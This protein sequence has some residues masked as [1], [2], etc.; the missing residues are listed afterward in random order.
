[1]KNYEKAFELEGI[2]FLVDNSSI[3]DIQSLF[4]RRSP[5]AS[6]FIDDPNNKSCPVPIALQQ[7]Q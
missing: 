3:Q 2:A 4:F 7:Q 1:V 5:V 6:V